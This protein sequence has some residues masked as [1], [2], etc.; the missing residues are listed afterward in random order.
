MK[1]GGLFGSGQEGSY[2]LDGILGSGMSSWAVDVGI[3]AGT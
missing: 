3:R 2:H 1:A